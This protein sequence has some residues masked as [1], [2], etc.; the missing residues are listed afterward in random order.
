MNR[1]GNTY[2]FIYAS[3]MVIIVAAILSFTAITLKP[4]QDRNVE[5]EKKQNILAAINIETTV[6][7]AEDIY[8]EKI[9]D[10]YT[11]NS[12]GEKTDGNAFTINLKKQQAKPLEER[13]LPIFEADLGDNGIKYVIPLRGS[14]LWGPI[15]G[16]VSL[17]DDFNTIYGAIFDHQGETPGLGAEITTD[18]FQEDF[19]EKT[20]FNEDGEFVSLIVAKAGENAPEQHKVDAI[21]GGTITSK[22]LQD[23]LYN[24]L[25]AYLEFFNQKK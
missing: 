7:E 3:V 24:D 5:I 10:S 21:S 25:S 4:L 22:G 20:L 11:I 18:A 19:K 6:E 2:T 15:W 13:K 1:N 14:G 17:N 8:A 9:T 16:Y 23:M 12:K